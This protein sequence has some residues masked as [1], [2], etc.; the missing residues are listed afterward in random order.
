MP[1]NGGSRRVRVERGIYRQENG[2]F[3]VCVMV[4]RRP[5][6][7]T[8]DAGSLSEARV[9][10]ELLQCVARSGALPLSPR[11]TFAEVAGRW[12][13]DFEAKVAAGERRDQTLDLYGSTMSP[14]KQK[15]AGA[16]LSFMGRT[17]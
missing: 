1:S 15:P 8:I 5:R 9:Q 3:A 14:A 17:G 13:A 10:R 6:F 12:L 4:E 16:G 11:L 7:R 2:R